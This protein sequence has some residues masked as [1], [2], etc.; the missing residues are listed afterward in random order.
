[1]TWRICFCRDI[2]VFHKFILAHLRRP[3][4][5]TSPGAR[6]PGHSLQKPFTVF[7]GSITEPKRLR[8]LPPIYVSSAW[9]S[10]DIF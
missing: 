3:I 1:M 4:A 10:P 7:V 8:A 5:D 2:V 6:H 9:N